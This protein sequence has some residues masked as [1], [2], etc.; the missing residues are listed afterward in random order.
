MSFYS[1]IWFSLPE[2]LGAN[3]RLP[4]KKPS[5]LSQRQ[6]WIERHSRPSTPSRRRWTRLEEWKGRWRKTQNGR[7]TRSKKQGNR[8][9]WQRFRVWFVFLSWAVGGETPYTW[10]KSSG[11]ARAVASGPAGCAGRGDTDGHTMALGALVLAVALAY[12]GISQRYARSSHALP[13]LAWGRPILPGTCLAGRFLGCSLCRLQVGF[14]GLSG[15]VNRL[16]PSPC[17]IALS[18]HDRDQQPNERTGHCETDDLDHRLLLLHQPRIVPGLA[19]LTPPADGRWRSLSTSHLV[20]PLKA[21]MCRE[22]SWSRS[23]P[24]PNR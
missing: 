9:F 10:Q 8:A 14:D 6:P 19:I 15:L 2:C 7:L 5:L 24:T 22:M 12:V 20:G 13:P 16:D 23:I 18:G 1:S 17:R 3:G 21:A 11:S 4:L